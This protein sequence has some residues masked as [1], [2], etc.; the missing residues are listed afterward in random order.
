M[1]ADTSVLQSYY[2]CSDENID[3]YQY[4]MLGFDFPTAWNPSDIQYLVSLTPKSL[5]ECGTSHAFL[6]ILCQF[7]MP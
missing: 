4:H 5:R 3:R 2:G 7:F 6:C 1:H